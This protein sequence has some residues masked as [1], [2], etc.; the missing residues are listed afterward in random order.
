MELGQVLAINLQTA[1][2]AFVKTLADVTQEMA[3]WM[4]PG[5]MH[6]LGERYAHTV[7]AED[8][9]IHSFAK[10]DAPLFMSAWAGRTGFPATMD[11]MTS[12]TSEAA[13]AFHVDDLNALGEYMRAVFADSE[14]FINGADQTRLDGNVDMSILGYGMVPFPVWFS[15]FVVGHVHDLTGEIS[16]LKG[17]QGYKGYPF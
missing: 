1:H 11:M 10:G 5:V 13:R 4:P 9:L 8:L 7:M 16:A 15:I 2:D 14:A 3:D 6:P 12:Q 17:M